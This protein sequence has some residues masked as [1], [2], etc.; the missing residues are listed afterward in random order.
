MRHVITVSGVTSS[1]AATIFQHHK[2][3][4]TAIFVHENVVAGDINDIVRE[5]GSPDFEVRRI[6]ARP[7]DTGYGSNRRDR[8]YHIGCDRE[9][10]S[11]L[12]DPQVIYDRL[13]AELCKKQVP[14]N[15]VWWETDPDHLMIEMCRSD[16]PSGRHCIQHYSTVHAPS[17]S[18]VRAPSLSLTLSLPR[19]TRYT[20]RVFRG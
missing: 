18:S 9:R 10:C 13:C 12:A 8:G 11:F 19:Q 14:Q 16:T 5:C 20:I 17:D 4:Q 2:A 3:A 6:L 15:E 1:A 7:E